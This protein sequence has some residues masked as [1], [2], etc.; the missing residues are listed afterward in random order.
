MFE[1]RKLIS[2]N[3]ENFPTK[4]TSSA[5]PPKKASLQI[6]YLSSSEEPPIHTITK[7]Q[8]LI[9]KLGFNGV[10]CFNFHEITIQAKSFTVQNGKESTPKVVECHS[11]PNISGSNVTLEFRDLEFEVGSSFCI[12]LQGIHTSSGK[13]LARLVTKSPTITVLPN[14]NPIPKTFSVLGKRSLP[15]EVIDETIVP[16]AKSRKLTLTDSVENFLLTPNDDLFGFLEWAETV[17]NV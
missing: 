17:V 1:S 4:T 10:S 13:V 6:I 5:L 15:S 8:S 7:D 16:V 11:L 14:N 2:L 9:I 3:N 12:S